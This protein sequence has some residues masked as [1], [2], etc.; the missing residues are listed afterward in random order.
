VTLQ[1]PLPEQHQL[2]DFDLLRIAQAWHHNTP[3]ASIPAPK[4]ARI[5][6]RPCQHHADFY[7]YLL[8][9]REGWRDQYPVDCIVFGNHIIWKTGAMQI[10]QVALSQISE[11]DLALD[12][13][14]EW[15][16]WIGHCCN[17]LKSGYPVI[18]EH[19]PHFWRNGQIIS[20]TDKM[21]E[22]ARQ[23]GIS[24]A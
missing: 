10:V 3:I 7:T 21:I 17:R 16:M 8:V 11:N 14:V 1:L 20:L 15:Q 22:L 23:V 2:L 6:G 4:V 24:I 12:D 19:M 18:I 9:F 13:W 5:L